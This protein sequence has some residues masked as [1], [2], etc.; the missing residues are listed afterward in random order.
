MSDYKVSVDNKG[1][2]WGRVGDID[3]GSMLAWG[4]EPVR[5]HGQTSVVLAITRLLRVR[6]KKSVKICSRGVRLRCD[7]I[8][9]GIKMHSLILE[10]IN[11][12]RMNDTPM[13]N[14]SGILSEDLESHCI[15]NIGGNT[16]PPACFLL[17]RWKGWIR[18]KENIFL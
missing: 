11:C 5:Y 10:S 2:V 12:G 9:L 18:V 6:M 15:P 13:N 3:V 14:V 7:C 1:W 17:G 16:N 8:W 4:G